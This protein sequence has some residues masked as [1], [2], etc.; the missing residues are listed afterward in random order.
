MAEQ[1]SITAWIERLK[2]GES[3]AAQH[4]W[5][6]YLDRLLRLARHRLG[7]TPRGASDEED[8]VL[9]VFNALFQGV[10]EDRFSRLDDREDL[11][12]VLVM[13]TE[14]K[15]I[16][17]RRRELA[18]RRGG[19]QVRGESAF[20]ADNVTDPR[21]MAVGADVDHI[22]LDELA[23][24]LAE[25]SGHMLQRLDDPLLQK[26]A[27]EKL[28]GFTNQEIAARHDISLRGLER[29]LQLIRR[30]WESEK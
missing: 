13:L 26:I 4:V 3:V 17:Q 8:V 6:E 22:S 10:R 5:A 9:S 12:Q 18:A 30:I 20:V 28:Q 19:G 24:H 21:A 15:V 23:Q 7:T 11:W 14:R 29:K 2:G 1:Q 27:L 25:E 16:A